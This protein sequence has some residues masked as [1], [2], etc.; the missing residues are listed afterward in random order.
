M[1]V[2]LSYQKV[3][4]KDTNISVLSKVQMKKDTW[5]VHSEKKIY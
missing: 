4:D 2:I 1:S 3:Y 5:V